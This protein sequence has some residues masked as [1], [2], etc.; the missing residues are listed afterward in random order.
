MMNSI[1]DQEITGNMLSNG[2]ERLNYCI[3]CLMGA[4]L[5]EDLYEF[6]L[7]AI[8]E[9]LHIVE[10]KKLHNS[11]IDLPKETDDG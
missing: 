3:D 7:R 1:I 11:V 4:E 5:N 9:I 10:L 8:N 2:V 6:S